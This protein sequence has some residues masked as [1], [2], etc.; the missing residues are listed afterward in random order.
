VGHSPPR[1]P[2]E[3]PLRDVCLVDVARFFSHAER[4]YL[5]RFRFVRLR[6]HRASF[7]RFKVLFAG[8]FRSAEK[9]VCARA[10]AKFRNDG[11]E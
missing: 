11:K 4:K 1:A 8:T 2:P 7:R 10:L 5:T 3:N 6:Q 9:N